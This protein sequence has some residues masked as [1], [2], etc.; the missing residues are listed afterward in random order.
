MN[1]H[2]YYIM[3][4][5]WSVTLWSS[6]ATSPKNLIGNGDFEDGG[7]KWR[8]DK[9]VVLETS[10]S[11]N[12][13][14]KIKTDKTK[15]ISFYQEIKT[16]KIKKFTLKFRVKKSRD[17][18]ALGNS[19]LTINIKR[20]NGGSG[21]GRSLP[22]NDKWNEVEYSIGESYV[23]G[24]PRITVVF[25]VE[26]AQ[27]G[28]ISF[29]DITLTE[30]VEKVPDTSTASKGKAE[31]T[32]TDESSAA[33]YHIF[34][35]KKGRKIEAKIIRTTPDGQKVTVQRRKPKNTITVPLAAFDT[36]TQAY[37]RSWSQGSDFMN[38]RIFSVEAKKLKELVADKSSSKESATSLTI[39]N[40]KYY[41]YRMALIFK[42]RSSQSFRDVSVEYT[43]Y[44]NQ[45][46]GTKKLTREGCL[47]KKQ[48]ITIAP[49]SE[50]EIETERVVLQ[51]VDSTH[52]SEF[53][54][55]GSKYQGELEGVFVHLTLHLDNGETV[56]KEIIYPKNLKHTWTTK[57]KNA[58]MYRPTN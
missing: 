36:K 47:Y 5:A 40:N 20:K 43:L 39:S 33:G 27:S 57:T 48:S 55:G 28:S 51:F 34:T 9:N 4:V 16:S 38:N 12:N 8:G 53:S 52:D 23:Q 13:I 45:E 22:R 30:T 11:K 19:E 41:G 58:Q 25:E 44:Y 46:T 32:A 2:L 54:S 37:I 31:D 24:E 6:A 3:L 14:C 29:D 7:A 49:K 10:K 15:T 21:S 18:K 42:N 26:P 35:D 50:Q 56:K 17:Y 1:K